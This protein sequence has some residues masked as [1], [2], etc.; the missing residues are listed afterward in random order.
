[1]EF[2]KQLYVRNCASGSNYTLYPNPVDDELSIEY[3]SDL[4]NESTKLAS[5]TDFV[6]YVYDSF[7][8]VI[9]KE[10]SNGGKVCLNTNSLSEGIYYLHMYNDEMVE[11]RRFI[12]KR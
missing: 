5:N 8:R 9:I 11:K 10:I 6:V 7:N 2:R 12:I 1:M 4:S 3:V